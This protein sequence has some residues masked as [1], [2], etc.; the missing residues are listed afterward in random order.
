VSLPSETERGDLLAHFEARA[1]DTRALGRLRQLAALGAGGAGV[2]VLLG[3]VSVV[4]AMVAAVGVLVSFFWW[5]K[6][7]R[8]VREAGQHTPDALW[9]HQRGLLRRELDTLHWMP[10]TEVRAV[11]VDEEA[12][13]VRL[14]CDPA[15]PVTLPPQYPD[16]GIDDLATTLARAAGV[17]GPYDG[18][19]S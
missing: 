19:Q 17:P 12:L 15:P 18:S 9:V 6:G 16:I 3:Q 8:A 11:V 10:W 13:N 14:L 2:A 4:V 7:S 1:S 5:R